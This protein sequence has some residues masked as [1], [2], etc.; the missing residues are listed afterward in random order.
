MWVV[1]AARQRLRKSNGGH[2]FRKVHLGFGRGHQVMSAVVPTQV[3]VGGP[4]AGRQFFF[5]DWA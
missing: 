5:G 4:E 2:N 1:V 3:K